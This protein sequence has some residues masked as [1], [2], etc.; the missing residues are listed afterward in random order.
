MSYRR[1]WLLVDDMNGCFRDPVIEAQPGGVHG[2]GA[3]LTAFGRKIVERYRM[4]EAEALAATRKHL[5]DLESSLKAGKAERAA[6]SLKRPVRGAA[7][8]RR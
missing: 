4:I 5:N 2:G 3:T 6:A 1:A 8:A 7:A